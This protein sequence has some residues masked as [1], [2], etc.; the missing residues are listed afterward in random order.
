M[1]L[2][3][4]KVLF[5]ANVIFKDFSTSCIFKN[6]SSL[7]EPWGNKL[8]ILFWPMTLTFDIQEIAC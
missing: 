8:S 7:G 3:V 5:K 2:S 1:P 4:F 6:F